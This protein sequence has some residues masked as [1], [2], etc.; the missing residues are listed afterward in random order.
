MLPFLLVIREE[1]HSVAEMRA[2]QEEIKAQAAKISF[3]STKD[4]LIVGMTEA[5]A[6]I[7]AKI[8]KRAEAE[9]ERKLKSGNLS[10][11]PGIKVSFNKIGK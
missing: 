8:R 4:D 6:K 2:K 5:D 11:G 1:F 9:A 10:S 3:A 7:A